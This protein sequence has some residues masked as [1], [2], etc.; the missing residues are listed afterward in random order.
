VRSAN[1]FWSIPKLADVTPV[2]GSHL[3]VSITICEDS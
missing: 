1:A 2:A 3:L